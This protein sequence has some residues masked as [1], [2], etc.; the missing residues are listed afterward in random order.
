MLTICYKPYK[1]NMFK[2]YGLK[3]LRDLVYLDNNSYSV[4]RLVSRATS[5]SV[6]VN[7]LPWCSMDRN[8]L[9][10]TRVTIL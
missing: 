2:E 4:M 6:R 1:L 5:P 3:Q 9:K 10:P 7:R 8:P